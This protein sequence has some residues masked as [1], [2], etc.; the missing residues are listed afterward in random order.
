MGEID[1]KYS[2]EYLNYRHVLDRVRRMMAS[3]SPNSVDIHNPSSLWREQFA[4]FDYMVDASPLIIR[5]LR[6]HCYHFN[7]IHVV[8]YRTNLHSARQAYRKKLRM[9]QAVDRSGVLVS[10]SLVL[11]GFG[12]EIDGEL[13]NSETLRFYE[14]LIALDRAGILSKFRGKG[15]RPRLVWEIG[16][17][18][19]GFAYQ[20]KSLFPH[21]TWLIMDFPEALLFSAVYLK[22]TFPKARVL[23]SGDIPDKD[24]LEQWE[25]YDFIFVP[26]T[27]LD[28]MNCERIDLTINLASF[29]EM[30]TEQVDAYVRKAKTLG[31]PCI[32]SFNQDKAPLNDEL[33]SVRS[34]LSRYYDISETKVLGVPWEVLP[35]EGK[36]KSVTQFIERIIQV[37]I[38]P[39]QENARE[40]RHLVGK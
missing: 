35:S 33:T 8:E 21:V 38:T 7:G 16:G 2:P 10:E 40:Y 34:I 25:E 6:H 13:Y 30:T 37:I 36:L 5:K 23:I 31:T 14:S 4:N 11:G 12:H 26:T 1:L 19:G 22:T 20:F 32:Y 28:Q 27:F 3:H 15:S 17:G 24:I 9:L 29:Q 18:W 39:R